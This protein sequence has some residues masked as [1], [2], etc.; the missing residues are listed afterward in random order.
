MTMWN[1][2]LFFTKEPENFLSHTKNN[3]CQIDWI[4]SW[5]R[6]KRCETNQSITVSLSLVS[7][8]RNSWMQQG[9][10]CGTMESGVWRQSFDCLFH[11]QTSPFLSNM[12]PW[13]RLLVHLTHS[14]FSLLSPLNEQYRNI[15]LWDLIYFYLMF[16]F[17]FESHNRKIS[18]IE[19]KEKFQVRDRGGWEGHTFWSD[20]EEFL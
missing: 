10:F 15:I 7:L 13:I 4:R 9:I 3:F 17:L 8:L 14:P 2:K 12:W 5:K 11:T 1:E 18:Y 19:I 20:A 6:H 16:R